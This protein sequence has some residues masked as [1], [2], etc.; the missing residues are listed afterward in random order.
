M[1]PV[2][3]ISPVNA[4]IISEANTL[5]H[6]LLM[7]SKDSI[8]KTLDRS[9]CRLIAAVAASI[10][11]STAPGAIGAYLFVDSHI[12]NSKIDK[13]RVKL[14][15]LKTAVL[16][17]T[18]PDFEQA[19]TALSF[20]NEVYENVLQYTQKAD[21][22]KTMCSLFGAAIAF[23]VV[24][25][26]SLFGTLVFTLTGVEALKSYVNWASVIPLENANCEKALAFDKQFIK[27]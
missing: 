22:V 1:T 6:D 9:S 12:D 11:C 10:W 14:I 27:V 21:R 23:G 5:K 15:D 18:S 16:D 3:T 24:P 26:A 4:R 19:K 13:V 2:N 8:E 17:S 7:D 25:S 20:Q